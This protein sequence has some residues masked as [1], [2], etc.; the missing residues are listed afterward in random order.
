MI[1]S[2]EFPTQNTTV[3]KYHEL[4]PNSTPN[5]IRSNITLAVG[6]TKNYSKIICPESNVHQMPS[7]CCGNLYHVR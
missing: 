5:R 7:S 2:T 1:G 4:N 6:D 3:P